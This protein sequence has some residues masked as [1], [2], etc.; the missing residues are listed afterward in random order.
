MIGWEPT[1]KK[2]IDERVGPSFDGDVAAQQRWRLSYVGLT[3]SE[4]THYLTIVW[5]WKK[6]VVVTR[7]RL[8]VGELSSGWLLR[9][10]FVVRKKVKRTSSHIWSRKPYL[11]I[12]D[13]NFI[14]IIIIF[15]IYCLYG[16][17]IL[18]YIIVIHYIY[19]YSISN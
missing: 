12:Y 7:V 9:I 4:R 1:F 15:S 11:L 6:F 8:G 14:F 13:L 19:I 10:L 2:K 3:H 18:Y 5:I 16:D 17:I